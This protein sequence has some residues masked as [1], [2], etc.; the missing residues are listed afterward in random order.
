VWNLI[1]IPGKYFYHMVMSKISGKLNPADAFTKAHAYDQF[2][3]Q[4]ELLSVV[5]RI[6]SWSG[7]DQTQGGCDS[8][9]LVPG[10]G[11]SSHVVCLGR[12]SPT[13]VKARE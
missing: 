8:T 11:T 6:E 3:M 9:T 1:L 2:S 4:R 5:P 13:A 10:V 12:G 7:D